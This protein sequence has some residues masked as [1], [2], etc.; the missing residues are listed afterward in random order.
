MGPDDK[1][2]VVPVQ[3]KRA[4]IQR[5]QE[6][7]DILEGKA[8]EVSGLT[9]APKEHTPINAIEKFMNE[10]AEPEEDGNLLEIRVKDIDSVPEVYYKGE[11]V[12]V[13]RLNSVDYYWE[14]AGYEE[15]IHNIDIKGA[16]NDGD[17]SWDTISKHKMRGDQG[18]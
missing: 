13:D 10:L 14:T 16:S 4:T 7:I 12:Y 8:I 15:S 9:E 17:A 11:P 5:L 3:N 2:F 18:G 6:A 1:E